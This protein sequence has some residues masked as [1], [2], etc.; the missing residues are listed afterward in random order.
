[1]SFNAKAVDFRSLAVRRSSN[2]VCEET[3]DLT[4]FCLLSLLHRF[5]PSSWAWPHAPARNPSHLS[6]HPSG[7]NTCSKLELFQLHIVTRVPVADDG[8]VTAEPKYD[9]VDSAVASGAADTDAARCE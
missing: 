5:L 4:V 1:M 3:V 9:Q 8:V 6:K 2:H 7:G